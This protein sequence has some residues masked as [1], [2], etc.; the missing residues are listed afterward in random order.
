[1]TSSERVRASLRRLRRRASSQRAVWERALPTEVEFWA[2]WIRTRGM[3]WPEDFSR[4]F[5][6]GEPLQEPLLLAVLERLGGDEVEILDVG[7]GPATWLG[8][9]HASKRLRITAVDPLGEAYDRL[10]ADAELEPPVRTRAV[11]GEQLVEVFGPGGFDVA[12]ARNA[13]DHSADPVRI[14]RAMLA[15]VRPGGFV[16]L[17][18]FENEGETMG[19]EELHQWNFSV[20]DGRLVVWNAR[21]RV[22][23]TGEL[24]GEARVT[25]AIEGGSEHARWVTATIER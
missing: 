21:R 2:E 11:P 24:A 16:V 3:D 25:A 14:V 22:D 20:A 15:V 1:M 10:L 12:Y 5:D 6:P 8:K 13:L 7:A 18:H 19:Y 17:R 9:T 4:R 23:V